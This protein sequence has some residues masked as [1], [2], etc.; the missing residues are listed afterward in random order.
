MEIKGLTEFERDLLKQAQ[1]MP[2]ESFKVMRKLGSKAR[3]FVA[4]KS[5][6][7]VNKVTGNY[8]KSWKRGKAY[9]KDGEY[10]IQIRNIAPH[11]HLIEDGHRIV[12]KSG[13]EHGFKE[14]EHILTDGI[15]EFEEQVMGEML[16]QWLDQLLDEGK[17]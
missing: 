12:D 1:R 6:K 8:H 13:N 2:K 14:G 3:T 17:L 4:K 10:Q 5:R 15:N 16:E 11:A 7:E 9:S